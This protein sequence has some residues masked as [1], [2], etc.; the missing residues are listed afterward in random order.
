MATKLLCKECNTF[1]ADHRTLTFYQKSEG[2]GVHLIVKYESRDQVI[3]N[4]VSEPND[5]KN[6]KF[7]PF[8]LLCKRCNTKLGL[9]TLIGNEVFTN[10][11]LL[12]ENQTCYF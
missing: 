4:L 3:G 5:K 12:K 2:D 8:K 7:V 6:T 1:I 9:D 11:V 10:K